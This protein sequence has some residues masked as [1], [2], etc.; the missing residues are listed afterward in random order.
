[1][2]SDKH[3]KLD[4]EHRIQ[5]YRGE[6]QFEL[7]VVFRYPDRYLPIQQVNGAL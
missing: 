4:T 6:R 1:M 2:L 7:G 5:T 3:W